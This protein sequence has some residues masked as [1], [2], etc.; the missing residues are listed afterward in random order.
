MDSSGVLT[1]KINVFMGE[2]WLSIANN[3]QLTDLV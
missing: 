1:L 3:K 2:K